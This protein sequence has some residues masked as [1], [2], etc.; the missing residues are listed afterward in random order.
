MW[1]EA[2]VDTVRLPGNSFDQEGFTESNLGYMLALVALSSGKPV[3]YGNY[4]LAL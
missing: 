1:G 3:V 4:L 2:D